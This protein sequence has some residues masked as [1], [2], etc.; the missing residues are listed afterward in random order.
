[1]CRKGEK[2]MINIVLLEEEMA[3]CG[4]TEEEMC[5]R[6]GLSRGVYCRK[7]RKGVIN[8]E[9]AEKMRVILGLKDP[10]KIFFA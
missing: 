10:G 7:I 2:G 9:E 3:R 5:Q 1:M 8:T 4:I 6:L